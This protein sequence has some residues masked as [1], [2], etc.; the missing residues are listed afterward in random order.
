MEFYWHM[1]HDRLIGVSGSIFGN[2]EGR[3]EYIKT[4]K[5]KH[6]VETRLRL[7]KKV[8]GSLPEEIIQTWTAIEQTWTASEQARSDYERAKAVYKRATAEHQQGTIAYEQVR[9][10]YEQ[11]RRIYEPKWDSY[12]QAADAYMTVCHDHSPEIEALHELECPAG[13]PWNGM[14]IFPVPDE[15]PDLGNV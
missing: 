9:Y 3:I 5:P 6:E 12:R 1:Y 15:N 8:K 13:C 2:I 10:V 11:A 4:K 7:L 14:T